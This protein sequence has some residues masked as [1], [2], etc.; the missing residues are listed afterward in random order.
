MIKNR[1]SATSPVQR[2]SEDKVGLTCRFSDINTL[3]FW[4]NAQTGEGYRF[5]EDSLKAGHSPVIGY[6][7]NNDEFTLVSSDPYAP[8]SKARQETANLDLPVGF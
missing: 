2:I 8:I 7:S 1:P 4:V 3:G 5:T 6:V